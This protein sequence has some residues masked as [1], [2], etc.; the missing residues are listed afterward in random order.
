MWLCR[1]SWETQSPIPLKMLQ[2]PTIVPP[3]LCD[4]VKGGGSLTCPN[5]A[6]KEGLVA[7][8][9]LSLAFAGTC[10]VSVLDAA[11]GL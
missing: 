1:S 3:D 7:G 8:S 9:S 10:K 11:H 4:G 5:S 2:H 6:A